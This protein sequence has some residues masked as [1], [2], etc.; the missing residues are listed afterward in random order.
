VL[1][2]VIFGALHVN[3]FLCGNV[4]A[5]ILKPQELQRDSA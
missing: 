4:G 3:L 5:V 2:Q 1:L